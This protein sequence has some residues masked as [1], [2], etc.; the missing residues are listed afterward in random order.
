[1][2]AGAPRTALVYLFATLLCALV[3]VYAGVRLTRLLA[4]SAT[5]RG[6]ESR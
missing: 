4:E 2:E 1:M 5:R 3:A 6:D